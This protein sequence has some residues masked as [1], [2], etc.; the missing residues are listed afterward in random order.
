MFLVVFLCWLVQA[1]LLLSV[2]GKGCSGSS[3]SLKKYGNVE[4]GTSHQ[5][6][7][8]SQQAMLLCS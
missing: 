7:Q 5:H 1:C 6:H 4:H 8:I 2:S 3:Q